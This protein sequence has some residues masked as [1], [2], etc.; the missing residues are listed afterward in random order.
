MKRSARPPLPSLPKGGSQTLTPSEGGEPDSGSTLLPAGRYENAGSRGRAGDSPV[1][2]E[3]PDNVLLL[4][5]AE[6]KLSLIAP[7]WA[8]EELPDKVLL[9]M[10]RRI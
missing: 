8:G 9:L 1:P 6:Q 2:A 10:V 5:I 7:P 4:I 3:F